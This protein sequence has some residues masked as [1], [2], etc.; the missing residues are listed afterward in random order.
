MSTNEELRAA[1]YEKRSLLDLVRSHPAGNVAIVFLLALAAC[2]LISALYP[3]SFR[4]NAPANIQILLRAIPI[5]GIM[6]LGVGLL[7]I[8]GEYDLSVG[9]VFGLSSYMAVYAFVAGW[10]VIP[11]ALLAIVIAAVFGFIN[12]W[13]TLSFGIPSFITTLGTLF[14]IRSSGRI[15]SGNRPL[16]FFPP[17]WY[18]SMLTGKLFG[19]Q[20]Q[21]LWFIGLSV[22]AWLILNRHW[23]GNHFFAVGGNRKAAIQVGINANRTKLSAF[24]LCSVF[25][26]FA[27]L[28]SVTRI[29]SGT[30]EPQTFMELEA[31][32]ACVMGGVALA[33]G[34]GSIVG[35]FIGASMFH[36]VKDVILLSRL[37]GY[38]LDF[39]VGLVIIF[40]VTMNG[41]AK[42]KY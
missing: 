8:A 12:G 21:F 40:G 24:V 26:A 34:R 36:L 22:L 30:T 15:V 4:F 28:L 14:I 23:L 1:R 20:A 11:A 10:P 33:G 37:P 42:K 41:L 39:F 32:A 27:G 25:A 17:D 16:S 18:Q 19:I 5:L 9:A 13:I 29:N 3:A 7:M 31:V 38:Y 35:I 6:S 2:V